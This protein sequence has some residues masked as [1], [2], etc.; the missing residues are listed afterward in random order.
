VRI[1][2]FTAG[3]IGAGHHVRGLAV[4]RGLRRARF[5]GEFRTFAPPTAFRHEALAPGTAVAVD[6]MERADP[7]RARE[8]AV[9]RALAAF[10]P[11]V[12][13]VDMFW[14]PVH[15]AIPQLRGEAWLLARKCPP[16]WFEG[17][18]ALRFD[19]GRFA[20]VF[21]IEPHLEMPFPH[22]AIEPVVVCNP[23]ECQPAGALRARLGVPVGTPVEIVAHAGRSGE[24]AAIEAGGPPNA[25][26]FDL[27]DEGSLFPAAEWL[28]GADRIACGAGYNSFWEAHWLGYAARTTFTPFARPIDDQAWRVRVCGGYRPPENGADTLARALVGRVSP[29]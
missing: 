22:E 24:R 14:A 28:G 19:R 5:S 23:D 25:R 3:T 20:R 29:P 8:G 18:P 7:R 15:H 10:D 1:A 12:L 9:A 13:V 6:P 27:S 26:V 4:R 16:V 2:Y 17:P 11:D 21:A